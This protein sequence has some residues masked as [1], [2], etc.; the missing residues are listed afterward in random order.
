MLTTCVINPLLR[1][2]IVE[3]QLQGDSLV[4]GVLFS[5][6]SLSNGVGRCV[7]MWGGEGT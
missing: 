6:P 5:Y 1:A 3:L 7:C 2:L 4:N